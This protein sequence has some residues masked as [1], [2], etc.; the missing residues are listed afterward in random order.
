MEGKNPVHLAIDATGKYLV[1]GNYAAGTVTVLAIE[2]DGSLGALLDTQKLPGEPGPH[3]R[4]QASSHPHDVPFDPKMRFVL[5][6]DKGLDRVFVFRLD[7]ASG[8]LAPNDP[9][10]VE[11]REGAGPRHIAFHPQLA[12]AYVNNELDSTVATYK[13]DGERGSLEPLEVQTTIPPAFT[14]NNTSSEIAVAP[15]G[16]FVYVSNRGHDSIAIFAAD[17]SGRL[18]PV[19]W[20]PTQGKTPRF[21]TLD[22]QANFLYAAN[23]DG[24]TIVTFRVDTQT[25]KLAPTGQVVKNL[26]PCCIV[27]AGGTG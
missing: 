16:R 12:I 18:A 25:G 5:V 21:F 17:A 14:G 24:D 11:A 10:F 22:P 26:S 20:E 1:T 7:A 4:E 13:W 8:K 15:S 9:P 3:R 23:Q 6:P 27:F 19:G 2:P